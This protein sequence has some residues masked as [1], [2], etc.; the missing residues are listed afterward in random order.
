MWCTHKIVFRRNQ[1]LFPSKSRYEQTILWFS[2]RMLLLTL[3]KG[4]DVQK[5]QTY[6]FWNCKHAE[7]DH[8]KMVISCKLDWK[9]FLSRIFRCG[10]LLNS[11]KPSTLLRRWKGRANNQSIEKGQRFGGRL[12]YEMR[13]FVVFSLFVVFSVESFEG[14]LSINNKRTKS[15]PYFVTFL[16]G[17]QKLFGP[18]V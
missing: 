7:K 8:G 10:L 1:P 17:P 3:L 5:I 2:I 9:S 16:D 18:R 6:H 12:I 15:C 13:I 4:S 14:S 11:G